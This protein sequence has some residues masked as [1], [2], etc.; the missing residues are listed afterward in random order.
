MGEPQFHSARYY[1][2]ASRKRELDR[3]QIFKL[4]KAKLK[5]Q[6]GFLETTFS[7]EW[8]GREGFP[9]DSVVLTQTY[10][11]DSGDYT[12][13]WFL[14]TA[15]DQRVYMARKTSNPDWDNYA[16]SYDQGLPPV[17]EHVPFANALVRIFN[18]KAPTSA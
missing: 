2:T 12:Q 3:A 17:P 13:V 10:Y 1:Y 8:G 16:Y 5:A 11:F 14:F 18:F 9:A 7:R 6:D 4:M 15:A